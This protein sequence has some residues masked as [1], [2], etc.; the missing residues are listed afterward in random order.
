M[1]KTT[2]TA[3]G[4]TRE[5]PLVVYRSGKLSDDLEWQETLWI[6]RNEDWYALLSSQLRDKTVRII[7]RGA[8][9]RGKRV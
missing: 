3:F 5:L 2:Y 7:E 6:E 9:L 8:W 1:P 4:E